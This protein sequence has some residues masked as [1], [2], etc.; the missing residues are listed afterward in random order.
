MGQMP[1]LDG[2]T[3]ACLINPAIFPVYK[4][5]EL[6]GMPSLETCEPFFLAGLRHVFH[7]IGG[8]HFGKL[9]FAVDFRRAPRALT[10]SNKRKEVAHVLDT[11]EEKI[12]CYLVCCI[13]QK[14]VLFLAPICSNLLFVRGLGIPHTTP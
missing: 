9:V 13:S 6:L 2:T 14:L 8:I 10:V 1:V 12:T 3:L 4:P 7:R 5:Y 11:L